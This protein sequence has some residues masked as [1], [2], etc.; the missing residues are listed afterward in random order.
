MQ[1]MKHLGR[2]AALPER[3]RRGSEWAWSALFG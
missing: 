1:R 3:H 2:F